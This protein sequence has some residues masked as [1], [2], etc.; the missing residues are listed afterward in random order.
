MFILRKSKGE[1]FD[2]VNQEYNNTIFADSY[3]VTLQLTIF[4]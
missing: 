4:M 2:R 1:Q 3:I